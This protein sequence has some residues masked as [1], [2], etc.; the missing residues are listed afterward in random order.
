MDGFAKEIR[1]FDGQNLSP[2]S[3]GVEIPLEAA[4]A[5]LL[6]ERESLR[7]S[8]ENNTMVLVKLLQEQERLRRGGKDCHF[9]LQRPVSP[10]SPSLALHI[11][12]YP[13]QQ[14]HASQY[15]QHHRS[16]LQAAAYQLQNRLY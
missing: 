3:S 16:L 1:R 6:R 11:P 14:Q 5:T 2:R 15:A 9:P 8:A 13:S 12:H 7:T 4:I 10:T